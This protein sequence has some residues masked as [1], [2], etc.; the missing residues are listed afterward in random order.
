MTHI[1]KRI[2]GSKGSEL[3][4]KRIILC[5]SGSVAA[6]KSPEVARELMRHGADV[7][8]IMSKASR[9]MITSRIMEWASGNKVVTELTGDT[10]HINMVGE[11]GENVDLVLIAP[12]TANTIS[13]SAYGIADT[14]ITSLITSAIGARTPIIFVPA[15]HISM[16][17][18]PAVKESVKKLEAVGASFITKAQEGKI[19]IAGVDEIVDGVIGKLCT[20]D[21]RGR[22]I[23]VTA[24]ATRE[25][26]DEVR[27][28]SSPSS[29][30]MGIEIAKEACARGACVTLIHGHVDIPIPPYVK[31]IQTTSTYDMRREILSKLKNCDVLILTASVAD[32]API[33]K[34]GKISSERK[35]LKIV[36]KR[37]PK[38]SDEIKKVNREV[39][40]IL[41]KAEISVSDSELIKM[42]FKKLKQSNADLI[43]ANDVSRRGIGFGSDVNE[44][45]LID[46][47]GVIGKERGEKK[48]IARKLL[49]YVADFY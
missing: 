24:G 27:F 34:S 18:N 45:I 1:S 41:F 16:Y 2:T 20:R 38:I 21:L 5:I 6:I 15:M 47:K 28:I 8:C 4:G 23:T 7:H 31:S 32:F 29:G 30:K 22:R 49:D 46:K 48:Y 35:E 40:L 43:L 26:I 39:K 33:K 36:L 12:A 44:V 25:F 14:P 17:E 10:E 9:G 11:K 13:K 37:L 19:K 42:A 3:S